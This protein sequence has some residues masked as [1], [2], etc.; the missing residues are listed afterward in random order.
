MI[1]IQ[2]D[3]DRGIE[4]KKERE[5]ESFLLKFL[6]NMLI[7]IEPVWKHYGLIFTNYALTRG[8]RERDSE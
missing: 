1:E 6:G 7:S 8:K 2:K 5:R 3:S 4:S